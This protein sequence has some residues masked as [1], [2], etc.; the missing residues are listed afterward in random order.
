MDTIQESDLGLL[1]A[2]DIL[3]VLPETGYLRLRQ[4]LVFIPVGK[5]CWW[6]G[7]KSGRYPKPVKLSKQCTA[8]RAED[9]RKLIDDL[10]RQ[11]SLTEMVVKPGD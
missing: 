2:P 9:I 8:W 10:S 4:V 5:R 6:Q 11:P 7:V 3:R 1:A